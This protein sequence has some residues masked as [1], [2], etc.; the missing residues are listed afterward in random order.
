MFI[1]TNLFSH[2]IILNIIPF[3]TTYKGTNKLTKS[4]KLSEIKL[5]KYKKAGKDDFCQRESEQI[6]WV[7]NRIIDKTNKWD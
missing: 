1:N 5:N 2:Y 4:C 7:Q 3:R 6:L